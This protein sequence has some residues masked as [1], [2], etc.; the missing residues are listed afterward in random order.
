MSDA[1]AD[2]VR[3]YL[4]YLRDP[5]G[6]VD[7]DRVRDLERRRAEVDDVLERLR[8]EQEIVKA[9]QVDEDSLRN[10]FV[11]HAS[12]YAEAHG[13]GAE[14][15]RAMGVTDDVLQTAGLLRERR[16]A[17]GG[18]GSRRRSR[19]TQDDVLAALPDGEFTYTDVVEATG[20]SRQTV[21][22]AIEQAIVDGRVA[23]VGSRS[24][25]RGQPAKV[26]RAG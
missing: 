7:H 21:V 19:V 1:A 12:D 23:E 20:A 26:F 10:A 25:G 3:A 15:F 16:A 6:A 11:I 18:G 14:A 24:M 17:S 9:G 22:K 4:E 8:L 5:R 2:A 13:I